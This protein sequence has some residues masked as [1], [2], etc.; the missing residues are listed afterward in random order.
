MMGGSIWE[1]MEKFQ[2]KIFSFTSFYKDL[3]VFFGT[4]FAMVAWDDAFDSFW[5]HFKPSCTWSRLTTEKHQKKNWRAFRH[6]FWLFFWCFGSNRKIGGHSALY[7]NIFF[8]IWGQPFCYYISLSNMNTYGN[9]SWF[10]QTHGKLDLPWMGWGIADLKCYCPGADQKSFFS[11]FGAAISLLHF[12]IQ[13]C[14]YGNFKRFLKKWKIGLPWMGWG[15]ADLKCQVPAYYVLR[16]N[17]FI[18][19]LHQLLRTGTKRWT[20]Y[21]LLGKV[22][23]YMPQKIRSA[24]TPSLETHSHLPPQHP[25]IT[26]VD[27]AAT[28]YDA[29]LMWQSKTLWAS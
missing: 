28:S 11:D 14:A 4:I 24:H 13:M 27:A 6:V 3:L 16:T 1:N 7:F 26:I 18:P 15:I 19:S 12:F 22:S 2:R 23:L 20:N 9:V 29:A 5:V 8:V 25:T 21:G 10:L 17:H